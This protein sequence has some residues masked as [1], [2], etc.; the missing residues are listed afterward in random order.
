MSKVIRVAV[1]SI[2]KIP[3]R[4][5][6]LQQPVQA[7]CGTHKYKAVIYNFVESKE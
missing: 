2:I 6:F 3:L 5:I 7:Q 4:V 1:P